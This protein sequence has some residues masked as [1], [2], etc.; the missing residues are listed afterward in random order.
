MSFQVPYHLPEYRQTHCCI[1]LPAIDTLFSDI[2]EEFSGRHPEPQN[3]CLPLFSYYGSVP[4]I[5]GFYSQEEIRCP[6]VVHPDT[7][8]GILAGKYVRRQVVLPSALIPDWAV[9][10]YPDCS[11]PWWQTD[12]ISNDNSFSCGYILTAGKPVVPDSCPLLPC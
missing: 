8:H 6:A 2:P 5:P 10:A 9:P 7:R 3:H 1:V 12:R 4:G 11:L